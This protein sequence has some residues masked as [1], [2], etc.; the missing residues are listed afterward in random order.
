MVLVGLESSAQRAHR[1]VIAC[2]AREMSL[3]QQDF[4]P[5]GFSFVLNCRHIVSRNGCSAVKK[6]ID[7]AALNF[8]LDLL[9]FP[10]LSHF[11][12]WGKIGLRCHVLCPHVY[13]C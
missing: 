11:I 13:Q 9:V 12:S 5:F 7:L 6:G 3:V 2:S 1:N 4:P 10:L 8:S